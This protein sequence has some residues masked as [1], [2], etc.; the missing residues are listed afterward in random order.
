METIEVKAELL[1][2][3]N[4]KR[5]WIN[6]V[7]QILPHKNRQGEQWIWV[8]KNGNNFE[9][10]QDFAAAEKGDTYPCRVYR[11]CPVSASV[12]MIEPL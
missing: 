12:E 10:G 11:L 1:F 6:R 3:L 5:E 2:V 8:D 9:C 7:P 4:N